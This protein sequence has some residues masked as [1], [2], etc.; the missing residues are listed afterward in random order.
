MVYYLRS[1]VYRTQHSVMCK[2]CKKKIPVGNKV[3]KQGFR[4]WHPSCWF[5]SH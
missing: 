3:I 2:R 1:D 5:E 4:H